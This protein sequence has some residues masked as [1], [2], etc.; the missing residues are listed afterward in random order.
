MKPKQLCILAAVAIL[1]GGAALIMKTQDLSRRTREQATEQVHLLPDLDL[2]ANSPIRAVEISD[3][4][5][6]LRIEQ[7]G[8]QWV[9]TNSFNYAADREKLGKALLTLADLEISETVRT[10]ES[11]RKQML[12]ADGRGTTV[13]LLDTNDGVISGVRLG[14]PRYNQG[15]SPTPFG[16]V[17]S[18]RYLQRLGNEQVL[19]V[20]KSLDT[21][22]TTPSDWIKSEILQV[23]AGDI[24]SVEIAAPGQAPLSFSRASGK[25]ALKGLAENEQLDTGKTYGIDSAFS[26][27]RCERVADPALTPDATGIATGT[28]YKATTKTH[29]V[30]EATI[31]SKASQ[32]SAR[33]AVFSAEALPLPE[34]TTNTAVIAEYQAAADTSDAF[35][36]THGEWT[37]LIRS[38]NA[39]SMTKSRDEIVTVEDHSETPDESAENAETE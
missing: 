13:T 18:G 8:D 22:T 4:A 7:Q 17:A 31:G 19:L 27:L 12:L 16:P 38:Q 32:S 6:T 34:G 9:V 29:T 1:L 20:N 25:L 15:P 36:Q 28:V 21:F 10:S 3:G 37:Y 35:N 33:Y 2:T 23:P 11:Q 30:Y 26:F 39:D 14:K 24:Q 5:T